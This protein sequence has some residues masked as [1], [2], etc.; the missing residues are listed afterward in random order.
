MPRLDDREVMP[1][2]VAERGAFWKA[3]VMFWRAGALRAVEERVATERR[4]ADGNAAIAFYVEKTR[5][6]YG[7]LDGSCLR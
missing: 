2:L 7:R 3:L 5:Q 6:T 1:R 4:I